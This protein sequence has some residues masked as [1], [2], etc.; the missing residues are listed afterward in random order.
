LAGVVLGAAW[1]PQAAQRG[2][3][4]GAGARWGAGSEHELLLAS[5]LAKS[6]HRSPPGPRS[7]FFDH[8]IY[9]KKPPKPLFFPTMVSACARDS[10]CTGAAASSPYPKASATPA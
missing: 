1:G 5:S 3:R 4:V 6:L 9:P 10:P 7:S 8:E 2:P